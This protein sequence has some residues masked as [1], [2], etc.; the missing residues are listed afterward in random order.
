MVDLGVDVNKKDEDGDTPI[1]LWLYIGIT[2]NKEL[3]GLPVRLFKL[4]LQL[5]RMRDRR[6]GA[7]RAVTG[8][9]YLAYRGGNA[10][11][12][13]RIQELGQY[14]ETLRYEELMELAEQLEELGVLFVLCHL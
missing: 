8:A 10:T 2:R 7:G 6:A 1:D 13:T 11:H 9:I 4:R 14:L 12:N 5:P 3:R